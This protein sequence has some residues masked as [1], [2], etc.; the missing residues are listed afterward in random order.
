MTPEQTGTTQ[1]QVDRTRRR[2]LYALMGVGVAAVGGISV[3]VYNTYFSQKA[4]IVEAI[5][6]V[7]GKKL[8][9]KK[10]YHFYNG[11]RTV[12]LYLP[13]KHKPEYQDQQ[14]HRIKALSQ[15]LEN[16]GVPIAAAGLE[17]IA[18]GIHTNAK[19]GVLKSKRDVEIKK[20]QNEY[21]TGFENLRQVAQLQIDEGHNRDSTLAFFKKINK[22]IHS[23]HEL[24]L[25][26]VFNQDDKDWVHAPG[27]AYFDLFPVNYGLEKKDS[28]YLDL[29][30]IKFTRLQ[31]TEVALLQCLEEL[32]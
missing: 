19:L 7:I 3:P 27:L 9:P 6:H 14:R 17:G 21:L 24:T 12:E 11:S 5:E 4:R 26:E 8:D 15:A 29:N 10:D 31:A 20:S 28:F 23:S 13:D 2:F 30:I 25:S 1:K 16:N 32:D 18:H 22:I